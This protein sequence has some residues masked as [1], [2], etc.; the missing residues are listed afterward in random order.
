[1]NYLGMDASGKHLSIILSLNGKKDE[2]FLPDC[3]MRHSVIIMQEIDNI[4]KRNNA[5]VDDF[6]F[7]SSVIGPGSFTGIRIGLATVKGLLF[8]KEIPVKPITS[9]DTIAYNTKENKILCVIDALHDNFYT[10]KYVDGKR[11]GEPEFLP[12][13]K[14]LELQNEYKIYSFEP[15]TKLNSTVV[16]LFDGFRLASED[17]GNL[18]TAKEL[19]PLYVRK[20]QAEEG[21]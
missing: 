4:L 13:N 5:K 12:L 21:R 7:I 1:M 3:S 9:F 18:I 8:G 20:S 16:S 17:E 10:Q 19:Y 11:K 2:I 15:L 6:D 14:V